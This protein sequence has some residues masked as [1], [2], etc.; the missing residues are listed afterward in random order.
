MGTAA[1]GHVPSLAASSTA[2]RT[3]ARPHGVLLTTFTDSGGL[4]TALSWASHI[5]KLGITPTV[6]IDG[7]RPAALPPRLAAQWR[8]SGAV[9]YGLPGIGAA[10][11]GS[12]AANGHER[13]TVRWLGLAALLEPSVGVEHIVLSDTDVVWLRDPGAYFGALSRLHPHLDVAIGTDH[14]TYAEAYRDDVPYSSVASP[15]RRELLMRWQ[16]I[17]SSTAAAG[18]PS[19]A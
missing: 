14:A 17:R 6:G 18:E 10:A 8:A 3:A 9:W 11:G 4:L 2:L 15:T 12:A 7:P 19:A 1:D 5:A 13:W 16:R